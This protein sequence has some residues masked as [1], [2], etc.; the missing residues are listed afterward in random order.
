MTGDLTIASDKVVLNTDGS[1]EFAGN[2]QSSAYNLG[3]N[4]GSG[5]QLSSNGALTSQRTSGNSAVFR[6]FNG[7]SENV[8]INADGSAHVCW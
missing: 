1:A 2:I 3:S 4:S 6:G 5:F 7:T 8:T